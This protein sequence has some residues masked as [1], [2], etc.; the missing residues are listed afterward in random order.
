VPW[1]CPA[2]N[3]II[4]HNELDPKPRVGERYRCH[5]CRLALDFDGG[6][7]KLVIADLE[8]DHAVADE[9]RRGRRT[10]PTPVVAP[11]RPR[12]ARRP[13]KRKAAKA[14]RVKTKHK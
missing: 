1:H 14:A 7:E 9:P 6:I 11:A 13:V 2:C 3:S 5:V 12:P 4:R 8:V 10:L